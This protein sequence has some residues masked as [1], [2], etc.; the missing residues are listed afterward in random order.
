MD[1]SVAPVTAKRLREVLAAQIPSR[2]RKHLVANQ[3]KP[4]ASRLRRSV[5][6][7]GGHSFFDVMAQLFPIVGLSEDALGQAQ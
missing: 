2:L 1:Y 5:E 6:I 7:K 4:D 3:V